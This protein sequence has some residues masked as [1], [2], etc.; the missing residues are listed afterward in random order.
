MWIY[1]DTSRHTLWRRVHCNTLQHTA[2]HCNT[3][4]HTAIHCRWMCMG[5]G[6][7]RLVGSI[8]LY[9]SFAKQT[10]ERDYILQK[11]PRITHT[12][13]FIDPTNRSQPI[14]LEPWSRYMVTVYIFWKN[15]YSWKKIYPVCCK[16]ED[17][18]KPFSYDNAILYVYMWM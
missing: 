1:T 8:K 2:P 3:L 11:R 9:V 13:T 15:V 6:W 7:L 4:Q 17:A 18:S 16:E 14:S 10:Y 12:H 5:W